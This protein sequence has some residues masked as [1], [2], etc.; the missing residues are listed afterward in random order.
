MGV[1]GVGPFDNDDAGDMAAKL[2]GHVQRVADGKGDSDDYYAARAAA[3]WL[4]ASHNTDILGGPSLDPIVGVLIRMR[5]DTRWLASFREPK[6][7]AGAL[8]GEL[9]AVVARIKQCRGCSRL[10]GKKGL[11][12][13]A[14]RVNAVCE[15]PVPKSS[16]LKRRLPNRNTA[17]R[18]RRRK[19]K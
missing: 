1:W 13:L 3:Q 6:K 17:L 5:E 15:A 9:M 14:A 19:Y 8:D 16:F 18:K 2:A 4:L 10:Y 12:T 7:M 11:R